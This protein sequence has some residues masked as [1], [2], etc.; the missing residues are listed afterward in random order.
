MQKTLKDNHS[1]PSMTQLPSRQILVSLEGVQKN[2]AFTW[3]TNVTAII[4]I[5]TSSQILHICLVSQ[6]T[7]ITIY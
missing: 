2:R 5:K 3:A 1:V 6:V 4:L 7:C